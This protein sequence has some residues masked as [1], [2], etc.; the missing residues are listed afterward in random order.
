MKMKQLVRMTFGLKP[1][2]LTQNGLPFFVGRAWAKFVLLAGIFHVIFWGCFGGLLARMPTSANMLPL[3]A[4][5]PSC[6]KFT[7][8][9]LHVP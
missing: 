9:F 1:L 5:L 2:F 7:T 6:L 4:S 3:L 8:Y